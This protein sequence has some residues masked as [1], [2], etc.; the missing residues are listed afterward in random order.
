[1]S[2]GELKARYTA[3]REA[4]QDG[5]ID[6][7]GALDMLAILGALADRGWRLSDD[8]TTWVQGMATE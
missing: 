7:D 2:D 6:R 8:E 4:Q 1:M 3:L 5:T